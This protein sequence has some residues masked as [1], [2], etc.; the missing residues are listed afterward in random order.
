MRKIGQVMKEAS[1]CGLGAT[2]ANHVFDTLD[3]FPY[4]Y[5]Q[6]LARA[7]YEPSFDLDAAL[8]RAREIT[9]RDDEEAHIRND[10]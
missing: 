7:D 8:E 9:G 4:I 6:E 1:H 2:A 5:E 3:K 10:Q